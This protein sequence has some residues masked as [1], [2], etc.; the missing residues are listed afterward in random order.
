MPSCLV[1]NYNTEGNRSKMLCCLV[2][3]LHRAG[4]DLVSE[5]WL[6]FGRRV[7]PQED[8]RRNSSFGEARDGF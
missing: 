2:V 6:L 8:E 5:S 1:Q 3:W 7:H 4:L